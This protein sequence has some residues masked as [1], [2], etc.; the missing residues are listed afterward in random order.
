MRLVRSRAPLLAVAALAG[1]GG[2]AGPAVAQAIVRGWVV[3]DSLRLPLSDAEVLI[4]ELGVRATTSATGFFRLTDLPLGTFSLRVRRIGFRPGVATLRIESADSA[5]VRI[6]LPSWIPELEPILVTAAVRPSRDLEIAERHR[7]GGGRLIGFDQLRSREHV[8]VADLLRDAG[9][10]ILGGAGHA[11]PVSPRVKRLVGSGESTCYMSVYL[12]GVQV[13]Q[14][15]LANGTPAGTDLTPFTIQALGAVE[16][17]TS[18][19]AAPIQYS[20][21]GN[22]CGVILLWTRDH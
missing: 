10:R 18:S 7:I 5:T 14:R 19:L 8:S 11:V 3:S 16:I 20:G 9:V 6:A 21:V 4:D 17:Y 15:S 22:A 1:L 2:S 12:D 13:G